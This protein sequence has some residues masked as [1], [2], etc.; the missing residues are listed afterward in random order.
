MFRQ[1]AP[2]LVLIVFFDVG[3]SS[4]QSALADDDVSSRSW[5]QELDTTI[6]P[7]Y[8]SSEHRTFDF[9]IGDWD[10]N[11]RSQLPGEFHHQKVGSWTRN[12]VFPVLGGK[13]IMEIAWDRDMPEQPSQ[14]G[15][16]IRYFDTDKNRWVMAQHW[17]SASGAG[18][19]MVDQLI[20]EAHHGRVSVYS[21]QVRANADGT[22]REEHR[23]YN[24]TDIRLGKS[25][26]WDGA[27]TADMGVTWNTWAISEMHRMGD[28]AP[29]GSAGM[30]LPDVVNE[31]LCPNAPHGSFD[32]LQ[33]TWVGD[34]ETQH[35]DA[36]TVTV[37]AG[38]SLDGCSIVSVIESGGIRTLTTLAYSDFFELWFWFRLDDQ[39]GTKHNYLVS[40]DARELPTFIEARTLA[41]EDEFSHFIT[42]ARMIACETNEMITLLTP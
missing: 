4:S 6:S 27:N 40:T 8:A 3:V 29:L 34:R 36:R 2:A 9:W 24:F 11:W 21:T 32:F 13:A 7:N 28:V 25:L 14:R 22:T 30:P 41:I 42:Q 12:R 39:P 33:G 38:K 37:T 26:R 18:W 15:M 10:V 20:G 17:P 35:G 1:I 23:R 16:S 19:A 5:A 31:L